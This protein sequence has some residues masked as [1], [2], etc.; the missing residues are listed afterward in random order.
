MPPRKVLP[1]M[2]ILVLKQEDMQKVFRME[3]AIQADKD[4]LALYS[5]GGSNIPLRVNL[6][7]P[8]HEGQSLYMPGYAAGPTPWASRSCQSIRITLKK[9]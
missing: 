1:K 4:A 2:E 5:S 6:D 8:E 7:V 9:V 3:D